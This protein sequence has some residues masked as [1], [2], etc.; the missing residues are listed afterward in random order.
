MSRR[1]ALP[2]VQLA[3]ADQAPQAAQELAAADDLLAAAAVLAA[4]E[5][6]VQAL[7]PLAASPLDQQAVERMRRALER[8][9]S[10][11]VRRALRRLSRRGEPRHP[12]F[13]AA[14][15]GPLRAV[16]A[17]RGLTPLPAV[18]VAS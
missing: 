16:R 11:A 10:P 12:L 14:A 3:A 7:G 9:E 15:E 18:E 5:E 1:T 13:V 8:V 6:V 2:A 4:R 17:H